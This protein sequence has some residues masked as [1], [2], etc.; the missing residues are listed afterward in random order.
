MM[1]LRTFEVKGLKN[2]E[3]NMHQRRKTKKAK[4]M[5][6]QETRKIVAQIT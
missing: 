4:E 5:S 1:K 2:R 3:P 6:V